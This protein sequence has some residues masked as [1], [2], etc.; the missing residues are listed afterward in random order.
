MLGDR[1]MVATTEVLAGRYALAEILG[2]GGMATVWRARD[3]VL[4][5]DVAVKVVSPQDA[6]DAGFLAR[7][8]REARHAAQLNHPRIVPVFDCGVANGTAFIVMEL[9]AGRTLR[10]ILDDSGILPPEQA[11]GIAVA[12]CEALEV[13]HTAGLMH[14][15][16]K[17]ANIVVSADEVKVLDFG[18]TRAY[19]S[20]G[21]TPTLGALGTVAYL[22]PE[23]SSGRPPNPRSDLYSLGCVLF[24]MLTGEPPFTADSAVGLAHRHVH[25]DPGP[26]SAR[27]PGV[28]A[29]LDEITG[30]LLAKD[31]AARPASAAA[32]R[33]GLL[34]ALKPPASEAPAAPPDDP[35]QSGQ[36]RRR[37]QR[38]TRAELVLAGALAAA[39][40]ALVAVLLTGVAGHATPG[41]AP[42]VSPSASSRISSPAAPKAST[43]TLRRSEPKQS[44]VPGPQPSASVAQPSASARPSPS[45]SSP[46]SALP[47]VAAAAGAFVSDLDAGVTDGQ[48]APPAGQD[49]YN[50]LQPLLFGPPGRTPQQLEQQYTQ[51]LQSYNQHLQQKQIT[52]AAVTTLRRD[53]T[54]LAKAVGAA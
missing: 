4:G 30:R 19:D 3:E 40:G 27:R 5:R 33:A 36:S 51:L 43:P 38:L 7:L 8:E 35:V 53:L 16:I 28:P 50:H 46:A 18:I 25:D 49:M 1:V 21:G 24:E 54:V 48:V 12:V 34:A 52:G 6:T 22:S 45:T 32:A 31:P 2:T 47:P 20:A 44:A 13:A 9:V 10:Q 15:D 14:R 23:Q 41:A 11:I 17:P 42:G 37:S 29:Q 26:P 39:L